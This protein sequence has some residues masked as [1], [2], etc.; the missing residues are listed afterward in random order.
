MSF[1]YY[2]V[3]RCCLKRLQKK[4]V[5]VAVVVVLIN[6]VFVV[7]YVD[8]SLTNIIKKRKKPLKLY[9]LC[10]KA[11]AAVCCCWCC[12]W[13]PGHNDISNINLLATTLTKKAASNIYLFSQFFCACLPHELK[14]DKKK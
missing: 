9:I 10:L 5:F 7:R 1:L 13:K 3:A 12:C 4:F 6:I 2:N 14:H 11:V 8:M